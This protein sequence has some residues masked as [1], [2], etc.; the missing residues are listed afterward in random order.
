[1]STLEVNKITPQ[2]VAT[3]VTLGD[4]GDTFTIPSGATITNNGTASGFIPD[5]TITMAK[6]STSA[7]EADNVKQRV[8]KAWVN[9]RG[10]STVA[11][12]DDFNVSSVTDN[13]VG[14]Y[15]VNLSTSLGNDHGVMSG[16][17]IMD[18]LVYGDINNVSSAGSFRMRT[19]IGYS[20]ASFDPDEV[21]V[22]IFGDS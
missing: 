9:F 21:H 4:S 2:G 22:I 15:T 7:T 1:M 8:A 14:N 5:N 19:V 13:S 6:L 10:S 20:N 16:Y 18:G 12:N 17:S 11:I 3:E